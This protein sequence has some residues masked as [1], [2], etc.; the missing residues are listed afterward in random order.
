MD[1]YGITF[2]QYEQIIK[3]Y[4]RTGFNVKLRKE[5]MELLSGDDL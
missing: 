4:T 5:L 2:P 3:F 1:Y